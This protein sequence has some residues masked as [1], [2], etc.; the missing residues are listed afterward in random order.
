MVYKN[1]LANLLPISKPLNGRCGNRDYEYKKSCYVDD[2]MFKSTRKF[3]NQYRS[4]NLQNLLD[5]SES[6]ATWAIN[7]WK[8]N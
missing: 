6:L 2:A 3:G 8:Y 1:V 7:R 4:W 5:R